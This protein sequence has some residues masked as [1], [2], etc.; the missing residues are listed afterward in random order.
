MP[1]SFKNADSQK[2]ERSQRSEKFYTALPP[3]VPFLDYLLPILESNFIHAN[4]IF[5]NLFGGISSLNFKKCIH[6]ITIQS[7]Y[8]VDGPIPTASYNFFGAIIENLFNKTATLSN[9][10][11]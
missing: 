11:F 3:L 8:K 9:L 5:A 1:N 4:A 2:I 6:K 10:P 7:L